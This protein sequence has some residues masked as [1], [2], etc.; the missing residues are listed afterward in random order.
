MR[1]GDRQLIHSRIPIEVSQT[2]N[3]GGVHLLDAFRKDIA[4]TVYDV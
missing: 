2:R 3:L 4:A 1:R